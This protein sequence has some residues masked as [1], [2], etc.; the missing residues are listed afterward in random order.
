MV[1]EFVEEATP[2]AFRQ[3]KGLALIKHGVQFAAMRAYFGPGHGSPERI[4]AGFA[5]WRQAGI[6]VLRA[7]CANEVVG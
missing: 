1:F 5:G 2:W 6:D 4:T 3:K 7:I